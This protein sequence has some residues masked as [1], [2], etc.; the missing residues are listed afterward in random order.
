MRLIVVMFI[1]I[2]EAN[3][4]PRTLPARTAT[5]CPLWTWFI[6]NP[7]VMTSSGVSV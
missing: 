1:R 4:G 7:R 5:A 2:R 6:E 3:A